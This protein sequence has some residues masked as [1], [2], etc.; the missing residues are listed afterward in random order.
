M[1]TAVVNVK[2]N[3]QVKKQA[4]KVAEELGLSLS[5]LITAYLRQLI[6]TKSVTFSIEEQPTEYLLQA[7]RESK[8][9]I[10][11]RRVSPSFDNTEDAIVWLDNPKKKYA[12]KVH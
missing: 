12:N 10:K 1:N 7:L 8:V 2:I 6:R 5:G 11:T 9:D 3:P 4:Q